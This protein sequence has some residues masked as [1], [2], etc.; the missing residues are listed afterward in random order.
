MQRLQSAEEAGSDSIHAEGTALKNRR[1]SRYRQTFFLCFFVRVAP[2]LTPPGKLLVTP[3]SPNVLHWKPGMND[4]IRTLYISPP[5]KAKCD[6]LI[7]SCRIKDQGFG[8]LK[9]R[10]WVRLLRGAL[11]VAEQV[12]VDASHEVVKF[13]N[14][15]YNDCTASYLV[16]MVSDGVDVSR[17]AAENLVII[18]SQAGDRLEIRKL[19]G[20]GGGHEL[21]IENFHLSFA[22]AL[23]QPAVEVDVVPSIFTAEGVQVQ[24]P[25]SMVG[26]CHPYSSFLLGLR[27]GKVACLN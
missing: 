25:N 2:Q 5:L 15:L 23:L 16:E 13:A 9:G 20:A 4:A 27:F 26:A 22:G 11:V 18:L 12:L 24:V 19:T 1:H 21:F 7:F 6:E 14:R 17:V 10:L 3:S 8:N